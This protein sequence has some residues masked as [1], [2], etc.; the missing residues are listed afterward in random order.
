ML[1]TT[2]EQPAIVDQDQDPLDRAMRHIEAHALEALSLESLASVADLSAYHSARQFTARFGVSPIAR[3]RALR[4]ALAA[5]L[6]GGDN[7]PTLIELAFDCGFESQ[8]GFTRA[9]KRPL[10]SVPAGSAAPCHR[11]PTRRRSGC[12]I[13]LSR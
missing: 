1:V 2:S 11:S 3:V 12:P 6:L 10:A 8:E 4:M 9:F 7:P 13:P 5:D